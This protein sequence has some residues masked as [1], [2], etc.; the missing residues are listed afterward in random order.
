LKENL[1]QII[2]FTWDFIAKEI[3]KIPK[4]GWFKTAQDFK[5]TFIELI[6][7]YI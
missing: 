1:F 6:E 2:F 4:T 3:F 7:D 5:Q